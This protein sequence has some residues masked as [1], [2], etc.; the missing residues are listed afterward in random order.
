MALMSV[1]HWI[2]GLTSA[3]LAAYCWSP[4]LACLLAACQMPS[5][6]RQ[7]ESPLLVEGSDRLSFPGLVK[8][9]AFTQEGVRLWLEGVRWEGTERHHAH[10]DS[11]PHGI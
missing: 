3:R 4:I 8:A 9:L 11:C 1:R 2:G 10:A 7:G 5:S 6:V